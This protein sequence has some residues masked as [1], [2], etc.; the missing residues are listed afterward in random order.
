MKS[1]R[2]I[3]SNRLGRQAGQLAIAN[4]VPITKLS[5]MK[6]SG[7]RIVCVTAYDYS[8]ARL[9]D[10]A[11]IPVILVGDSLGNVVLGLESTIPVT[12]VDMV[13]HTKAVVRGSQRALIVA[14]LPFLSYRLSTAETLRNAGRLLQE[15]GAQAVKLEGGKNAAASIR[16]L[17]GSGI[18]VMGHIGLEPQSANQRGG[19]RVQRR[20][21]ARAREIM[22]DALAVEEAGA[23]AIV[24]ELIPT[25][26]AGDITSRLKIPTIGIGAGPNCDGQIQVIYDILGLGARPPRH[27]KQYAH[28]NETILGSLKTYAAEVSDGIF[29]STD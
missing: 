7:S 21:A 14:D 20:T 13:R 29:P 4:R 12:M 2:Q 8:F 5:A 16:S 9:V 27:A 6:R 11:Q 10:E 25:E 3:D 23:F 28:L 15:G 19:F 26:L 22:E 1:H 18:P 24:L 17:T